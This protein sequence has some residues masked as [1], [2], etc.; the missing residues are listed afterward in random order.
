MLVLKRTP[1]TKV[2]P[3]TAP[4][5]LVLANVTPERV[6]V[7]ELAALLAAFATLAGEEL[8][9]SLADVRRGSAKYAFALKS[10]LE[11]ELLDRISTAN[12]ALAT[13][14]VRRAWRE[15]DTGLERL[16]SSATVTYGRKKLL[17]FPG[18]GDKG[19]I[20]PIK[21]HEEVSGQIIR[22]GGRTPAVMIET[23][24]GEAVACRCKTQ[25]AKHLAE[26]LYGGPVRLIGDATWYR[27]VDGTWTREHFRVRSFELLTDEPLTVTIERARAAFRSA[28]SSKEAQNEDHSQKTKTKN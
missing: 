2:A 13:P 7:R 1:R 17:Q 24:T 22:A 11:P 16:G 18:M 5:Q 19:R 14:E 27:E 12:S 4:L 15:M 28:T 25:T 21:Q 20:G 3:N 6:D 23:I 10:K 26:H 8:Q 9:F